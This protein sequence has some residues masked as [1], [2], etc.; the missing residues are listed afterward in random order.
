M[1]KPVKHYFQDEFQKNKV[2]EANKRKTE[3]LALFHVL[4]YMCEMHFSFLSY[5]N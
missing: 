5:K 3:V 1:K 2:N 4:T